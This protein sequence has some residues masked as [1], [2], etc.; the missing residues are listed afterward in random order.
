MS[1]TKKGPWPDEELE[2]HV[3]EGYLG[4]Q[5]VWVTEWIWTLWRNLTAGAFLTQGKPFSFDTDLSPNPCYNSPKG[6]LGIFTQ[7]SLSKSI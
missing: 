1:K 6:S 2:G 4:A 7:A 5:L 3:Y